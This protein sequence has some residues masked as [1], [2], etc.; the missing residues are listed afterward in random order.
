LRFK[1]KNYRALDGREI[2][3]RDERDQVI[4]QPSMV[5]VCPAVVFGH[6]RL[7]E[8]VGEFWNLPL[9]HSCGTTSWRRRSHNRSAFH[10]ESSALADGAMGTAGVWTVMSAI[11]QWMVK[12]MEDE[13]ARARNDGM[14]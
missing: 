11:E 4:G 8:E 7:F 14:Q 6:G 10:P 9:H 3:L 12:A 13:K 2:Y 5:V 1:A